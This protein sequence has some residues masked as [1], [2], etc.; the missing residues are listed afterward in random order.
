MPETYNFTPSPLVCCRGITVTMDGDTIKTVQFHGGC[1]GNTA[2][3]SCLVRERKAE[4]V[5]NLLEG[6]RCGA[7]PTSCPDQLA[8]FLKEILKKKSGNA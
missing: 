5:A 3:I 8:T 6:V 7:K 4:E 1:P 2:G